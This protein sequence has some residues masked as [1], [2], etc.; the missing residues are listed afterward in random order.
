MALGNFRRLVDR[1]YPRPENGYKIPLLG[2]DSSGRTTLLHRLK[3]G[4]IAQTIPT[5]GFIV[6]EIQ[7]PAGK[8]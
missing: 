1:F 2:L 8:G 6:G 7:V 3:T 4:E 5:I